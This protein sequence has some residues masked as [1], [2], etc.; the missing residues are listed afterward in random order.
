MRGILYWLYGFFADYGFSALRPLIFLLLAWTF[1]AGFAALSPGELG[2]LA[3]RSD[4][5]DRLLQWFTFSAM[6]G[7]PVAGLDNAVQGLGSALFT[8]YKAIARNPWFRIALGADKT[9]T[10]VFVFL[11][12]LGLRNHFKM[13]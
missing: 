6:H 12:G 13:R 4:V 8:D 11:I 2:G 5:G 9:M 7:L 10:V 1:G 3:S